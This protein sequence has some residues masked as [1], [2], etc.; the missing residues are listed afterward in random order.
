[1][2]THGAATLAR[3]SGGSGR[4]NI[5]ACVFAK[6][7]K[8]GAFLGGNKHSSNSEEEKDEMDGHE[9]SHQSGGARGVPGGM[10]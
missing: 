3:P 1:M 4:S 6:W 2:G 7:A 8:A 5:G 10:V 9:G